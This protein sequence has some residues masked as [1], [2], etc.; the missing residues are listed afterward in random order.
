MDLFTQLGVNSTLP[1]QL[2]TFI[3]AFVVL[4]YLL[5][6]PYFAAF[7]ER[8]ERT[9]GMTELA[10]RF[11]AEARELEEKYTMRAQEVND[12]FREIYDKSRAETM[13][14]YDRLIGEARGKT[15]AAVEQTRKKIQVEMEGARKQLQ[16]EVG[17]VTQLISQKLIGKDLAT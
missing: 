16:S 17:S 11:V 15:R 2:A 5:F 1:Y 4:K 9:I 12:R 14:E 7:N 6:K 10:E 3:V 8:R 13:Q